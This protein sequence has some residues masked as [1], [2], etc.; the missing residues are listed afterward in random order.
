MREIKFRALNTKT[1]YW[2][3]ED[4][5]VYHDGKFYEDWRSFEDGFSLNMND[6]AVMQSTGL[7]DKNGVEIYEGDIV[8]GFQNMTTSPIT[9]YEIQGVATYSERY[10]MFYLEEGKSTNDNFISSLG[11][12]IYTLEVIGNIYENKELLE[13]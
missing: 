9:P 13:K 5:L 8:R 2:F 12:S 11:G 6:C 4:K 10:T 3:D 1:K 7:E